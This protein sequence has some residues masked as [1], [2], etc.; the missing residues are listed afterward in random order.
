[1]SS[2]KFLKTRTMKKVMTILGTILF[3]S[4]ILI[5]CVDNSSG[6]KSSKQS[7]EDSIDGIYEG[8]QDLGGI[9][10]A[11]TLTINGNTWSA[12]SQLGSASPEYN[13][14]VVKGSDL[15]D[16]SGMIKIGYVS[17]KTARMNGYPSM[18]K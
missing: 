9:V 18:S 6:S 5:S 15:Y 4:F 16:E 7:Q 8:T 2:N 10:L 13:S 1:M 3:V 12:K 11:A 17:G 14:G